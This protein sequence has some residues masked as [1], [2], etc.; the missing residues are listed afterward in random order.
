MKKILFAS[1]AL[2][3]TAGMAAADINFSGYGRFGIGYLENRGA[4]AT[5]TTNGV[6]DTVIVSRFRVSIDGDATTDGGVRFSAR[7]R[8]Q[9]D[10]TAA[11]GN[12]GAAGLNAAR[13][14][15]EYEGLRVDVGNV[16]GAIDNLPGYY[17]YETGLEGMQTQYSGADY[18][19]TGYSSTGG[20]HNGVYARYAVGDFA[21]AASYDQATGGSAT[22]TN[23]D[24]W[25]IH[26]AYTFGNITAA[27][28]YGETDTTVSQDM[29]VFTLGG[30]WGAFGGTLFVGDETVNNAA[31]AY[32]ASVSDTFYGLS[33]TYDISSA[34]TI[35]FAYGDGSGT[36]DT[37]NYGI[38][39]KHD[40]GG[41]VS[42]RGGVGNAKTAGVSTTRADFG[43]QF[44][45]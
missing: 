24:R 45:F 20:T 5:A 38:G 40:L 37:Q 33:A 13:F 25:D 1:T 18:G 21:V 30:T 23:G 6:S 39:V 29:T 3:A 10:E 19:F 2:I 36:G 26:G 15:V 4:A 27:L 8:I 42:L 7:V 35:G 17:G 22:A 31:G 9:A 41:G 12:A 28:A 16:A 43:A 44:N 34:T 11:N 32:D 14:S